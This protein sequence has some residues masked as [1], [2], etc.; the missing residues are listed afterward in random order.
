METRPRAVKVSTTMA[1]LEGLIIALYALADL[2]MASRMD[3]HAW[4]TGGVYPLLYMG[5]GF[6]CAAPL[7]LIIAT[8]LWNMRRWA[9]GTAFLVF[10]IVSILAG[11]QFYPNMY[12][13]LTMRQGDGFYL[14]GVW[15]III[16]AVVSPIM[17]LYMLF[18]GVRKYYRPE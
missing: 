4:A 13:Y 10:L 14:M 3:K 15:T 7:A 12:D 17:A 5:C 8:G 1:V 18:V 6:L 16:S 9:Y 11:S 2:A